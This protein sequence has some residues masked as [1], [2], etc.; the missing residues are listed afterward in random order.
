[1]VVFP[2]VRRPPTKATQ[3]RVVVWI[4][5][6]WRAA[7]D[8]RGSAVGYR[9]LGSR[10]YKVMLR[11]AMFGSPSELEADAGRFWDES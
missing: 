3:L 8:S 4:P 6:I 5:S 7:G 11:A 2:A 10:E 1:M 9:A